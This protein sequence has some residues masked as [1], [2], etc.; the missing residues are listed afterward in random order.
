MHTENSDSSGPPAEYGTGQE[1]QDMPDAEAKSTTAEMI[2]GALSGGSRQ[3]DTET[4]QIVFPGRERPKTKQPASGR[5][6][7]SPRNVDGKKRRAQFE[8]QMIEREETM[9]V[10]RQ[11]KSANSKGISHRCGM[12]DRFRTR[13]REERTINGQMGEKRIPFRRKV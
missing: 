6:S 11:R 9:K 5:R 10:A 7:R 4:S 13:Q 1:D 8:E 3:L 12:S 2:A